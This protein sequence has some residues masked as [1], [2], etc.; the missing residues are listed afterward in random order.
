MRSY[1]AVCLVTAALLPCACSGADAMPAGPVI[2]LRAQDGVAVPPETL[3]ALDGRL[4]TAN[5]GR[6]EIDPGDPAVV[7]CHLAEHLDVADAEGVAPWV[8]GRGTLEFRI[9]APDA[10]QNAEREKRK[11]FGD[12]YTPPE[13]TAWVPAGMGTVRV[14]GAGEKPDLLVEIPEDAAERELDRGMEEGLPPPRIEG[15]RDALNAVHTREVFHE[16]DI[17]E[18]HVTRQQPEVVVYFRITEPRAD[19]FH[20]FTERNV[21][22]QLALVVNG[23]VHSAPA[24]MSPLPG[25][26]IIAGGGPGFSEHEAALLAAILDGGL[27]LDAPLEVVEVRAAAAGD[28]DPR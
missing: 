17:E 12:R 26:G 9:V 21:R 4:W 27:V 20:S 13:G 11:T 14:P 16:D 15:L 28:A 19:D 18:A 25:E 24:I 23:V 2:V 1:P 10:M 8:A 5:L 3:E 6:A 7:L 22:R